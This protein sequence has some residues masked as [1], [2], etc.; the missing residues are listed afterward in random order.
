MEGSKLLFAGGLA[1]EFGVVVYPV[2]VYFQFTDHVLAV[3][4][5]HKPYLSATFQLP[6]ILFSPIKCPYLIFDAPDHLAQEG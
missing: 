3:L 5:N 6:T 2:S 1:G 4:Y